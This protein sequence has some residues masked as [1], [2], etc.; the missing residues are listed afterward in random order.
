MSSELYQQVDPEDVGVSS[1]YLGNVDALQE[2]YL[3]ENVAKPLKLS[4]SPRKCKDLPSGPESRWDISFRFHDS[5][6]F[7]HGISSQLSTS[8]GSLLVSLMPV[9]RSSESFDRTTAIVVAQR[10]LLDLL[11][12]ISIARGVRDRSSSRRSR[13]PLRNDR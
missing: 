1:A 3:A 7:R 11:V 2:R 6:P 12:F 5:T 9:A 4:G 13:L 10:A 8:S